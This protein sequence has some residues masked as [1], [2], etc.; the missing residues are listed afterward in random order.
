MQTNL[1][2]LLSNL[3]FFHGSS[4]TNYERSEASRLL[5]DCFDKPEDID[6]CAIGYKNR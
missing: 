2:D 6:Y 3:N 1:Q 5:Y 4:G